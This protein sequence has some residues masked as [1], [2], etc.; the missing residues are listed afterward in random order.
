MK[1]YLII[2]WEADCLPSLHCD[3]DDQEDTGGERE[4]TAAL[5]EGENE[6]DEAVVKT[7]VERQDKKI[8]DK[9]NNISDAEAGEESV[10]EVELG[11]E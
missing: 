2:L 3:G 11:P 5:K 7:K 8:G 1:Q 6:V 4:V 9:E 10:E